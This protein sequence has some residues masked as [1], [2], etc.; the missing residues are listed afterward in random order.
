MR[1][2]SIAARAGASLLLSASLSAT[3]SQLLTYNFTTDDGSFGRIELTFADVLVDGTYWWNDWQQPGDPLQRLDIFFTPAAGP[4][5]AGNPIWEN[6]IALYYCRSGITYTVTDSVVSID[7]FG[8]NNWIPPTT[9]S[10]FDWT[11]SYNA[12][13]GLYRYN[14]FSYNNS[15]DY[16]HTQEGT[17]TLT[18]PVPEPETY[19]MMLLGLGG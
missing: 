10:F 8:G 11:I 3:A 17:L 18:A 19:A 9:P 7:S 6:C 5:P 2:G 1:L 4:G 15:P 12:T 13:T 16:R 14:E